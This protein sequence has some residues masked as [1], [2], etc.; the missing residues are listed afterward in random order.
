MDVDD[1]PAAGSGRDWVLPVS[2]PQERALRHTVE[3]IVDSA[4]DVPSLDVPAPQMAPGPG[5]T[6]NLAAAHGAASHAQHGAGDRS[7]QDHAAR[8]R[9]ALADQQ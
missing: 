3:Q 7:A 2:G 6:P 8:V 9:A 5:A 1:V 4:A